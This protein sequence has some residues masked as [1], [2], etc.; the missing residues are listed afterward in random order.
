MKIVK[1]NQLIIFILTAVKNG[2]ILHGHVFINETGY[3]ISI[4][5]TVDVGNTKISNEN[6]KKILLYMRARVKLN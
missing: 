1:K 4:K 5:F 2:C 6:K 3:F